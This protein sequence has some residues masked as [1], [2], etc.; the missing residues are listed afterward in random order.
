MQSIDNIILSR[1]YGTGRGSVFTPT[2]F[3]DLATQPAP[4]VLLPDWCRNR[5]KVPEA[6]R[7]HHRNRFHSNGTSCCTGRYGWISR[8]NSTPIG[9]MMPKRMADVLSWDILDADCNTPKLGQYC[10]LIYWWRPVIARVLLFPQLTWP[11]CSGIRRLHKIA[12]IY[13]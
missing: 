4:P 6:Q 13:L 2:D 10:I 8:Q 3:L 7:H 9:R 12:F 1:I 5:L 11:P